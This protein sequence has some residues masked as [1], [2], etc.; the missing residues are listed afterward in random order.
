MLKRE[1]DIFQVETGEYRGRTP[2]PRFEDTLDR[3]VA[4]KCYP[5]GHTSD[6]MSPLLG[7]RGAGV[8]QTSRGLGD[9][10]SKE[11]IDC[12]LRNQVKRITR[13]HE[14]RPG[15][16]KEY[17]RPSDVQLKCPNRTEQKFVQKVPSK[18]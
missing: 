8:R 15:M 7:N 3:E 17:L 4:L 9:D 16:R 5:S 1:L 10:L 12:I 18:I 2:C 6:R 11:I 14:K 13:R